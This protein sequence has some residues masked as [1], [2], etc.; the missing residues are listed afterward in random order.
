M[1]EHVGMR[2]S[3]YNDMLHLVDYTKN[4]F[5]KISHQHRDKANIIR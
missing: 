4:I 2:V 3:Q 5:L 1:T